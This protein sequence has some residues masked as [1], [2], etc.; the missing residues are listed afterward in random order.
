MMED[1]VRNRMYLCTCDWI[2]LLYS[3]KLTEQ[4]KPTIKEKIKII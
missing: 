4:C 3:R 2:D 1:N